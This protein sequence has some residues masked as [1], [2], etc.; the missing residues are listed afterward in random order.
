[1]RKF[2]APFMAILLFLTLVASFVFV[3]VRIGYF[4]SVSSSAKEAVVS[5]TLRMQALQGSRVFLEQTESLRAE[6]R[7]VLIQTDNSV[8]LIETVEDAALRARV[9][10][11]VG[12]VSELP[13][14]WQ[15]HESIR[16]TASGR[17]TLTALGRFSK[18]LEALPEASRIHSVSLQISSD[19]T[20]FGTFVVDFVKEQ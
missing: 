14:N 3:F 1:M 15:Y 5:S 6:L 18:E 7:N 10:V 4:V 13:T 16:V 2:I 20:W 17:G 19:N 12:S 11:S 8:R 9:K